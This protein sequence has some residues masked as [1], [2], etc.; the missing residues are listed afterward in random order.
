MNMKCNSDYNLIKQIFSLPL[1]C[2]CIA[3]ENWTNQKYLPY[4]FL[5]LASHLVWFFFY[6]AYQARTASIL[7]YYLIPLIH[8]HE[9]IQQ[10]SIRVGATQVHLVCGDYI[11][12]FNKCPINILFDWM[13]FNDDDVCCMC[14]GYERCTLYAEWMLLKKIWW[15][16]LQLMVLTRYLIWWDGPAVRSADFYD[17]WKCEEIITHIRHQLFIIRAK[18]C[19]FFLWYTLYA[20]WLIRGNKNRNGCGYGTST[21]I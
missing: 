3:P 1:M 4:V 16:L 20:V 13:T 5:P 2:V 14:Y 15:M 8:I 18:S 12:I 9:N 21:Y 11:E 10:S 7:N 17:K 6:C 19:R